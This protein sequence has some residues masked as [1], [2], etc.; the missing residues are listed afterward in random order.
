M[1]RADAWLRAA[2]GAAVL[3][4]GLLTAHRIGV[5]PESRLVLRDA[6]APWIMAAEPFIPQRRQA[7]ATGPP[8]SR[9]VREV[10]LDATDLAGA[11]PARLDLRAFGEPQLFV[12]DRAVALV[13]LDASRPSWRRRLRADLSQALRPG[14]N[15]LQV[16]V[17]NPRGPALLS[18]RLETGGLVLTSGSDWQASIAARPFEPALAASDLRR[19]P[20]AG[21]L[22]RPLDG[23]AAHALPLA[24]IFVLCAG[25]FRLAH[26]ARIGPRPLERAA[27]AVLLLYWLAFSIGSVL[28]LDPLIGFDARQHLAYVE[29][30]LAEGRLPLAHEGWSTFHPPL[31]YTLCAAL[32]GL[33]RLVSDGAG[34]VLLKLAS[35]LA[36]LGTAL[37]S[38]RLAAR[39]LPDAPGVRPAALLFAGLLPMSLELSAY[40]SNEAFHAFLATVVLVSGVEILLD[41]SPS[42]RRLALFS[43]ALGLALL[44]KYT[45]I[46]LAGCALPLLAVHVAAARRRDGRALVGLA[47]LVLPALCVAG[48]LYARNT[49]VYGRP[50]VANWDL[51]PGGRPWWLAP[52][53]HTS[54][55]YL[56]FGT[57]LVEPWY[58]SFAGFWDG[59]HATLWGDG[60][61]AGS[62]RAAGRNPRWSYGWMAAGYLLAVP[63]TAL[64]AA[65]GADL[66]RRIWRAP[67]S[68]PGP[69]LAL[70]LGFAAALFFAVFH[71][72]LVLPYY[73]QTKAF[74][75]LAA[76]PVL[77]LC[78]AHALCRLDAG[79]A[80]R[81]DPRLGSV[82]RAAL[83][84]LV[85]STLATF[86]LAH[87]PGLG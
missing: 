67:R 50:L 9:F 57:A 71:A 65:G 70:S 14:T 78:M 13:P 83:F 7:P 84:G 49:F 80:R 54:A 79:L 55:Y 16:D 77:A 11:E 46:V 33:G 68:S 52:G 38:A 28:P 58:A 18:L 72:T 40:V 10:A 3:A 41:P 22:P 32:L 44:T 21:A 35:A 31:Y 86:A 39:L 37:L 25:G 51:G 43:L 2:F 53:F 73:G 17:R 23:L 30:I 29:Q 48:W 27:V 26:A 4:A 82:V 59:L 61:L 66:A 56:R 85:G 47:A 1:A 69:A 81:L 8:L 75:A 19:H 34:L 42:T 63:A 6:R 24:L 36:G 12:N 45:A 76:T 20:D 5:S 64:L 15:V 74:Y 62:A 60:L 87:L